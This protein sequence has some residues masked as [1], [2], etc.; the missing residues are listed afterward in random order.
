MGELELLLRI[1][2]TIRAVY[3]VDEDVGLHAHW[4]QQ[5]RHLRSAY[6]A[7]LHTE[8]DAALTSQF[9][10][11]VHAFTPSDLRALLPVVAAENHVFICA[12]WDCRSRSKAGK[13]LGLADPRHRTLDGTHAYVRAAQALWPGRVTYLL[14]NVAVEPYQGIAAQAS[15]AYVRAAFGTPLVLDAVQ[16]G[17]PMRRKRAYWTNAFVNSDFHDWLGRQA[18]PYYPLSAYLHQGSSPRM[19]NERDVRRHPNINRL[20]QPLLLGPTIV[21][22]PSAWASPE[23]PPPVVRPDGALSFLTAAE[24]E[25]ALGYRPGST[26]AGDELQRR[27]WLGQSFDLR[28]LNAILGYGHSGISYVLERPGRPP[29]LPPV[30]K[31]TP[32]PLGGE[33][34]AGQRTKAK[35]RIHNIQR[36]PEQP[37]VEAAEPPPGMI[38]LNL[39][40]VVGTHKPDCEGIRLCTLRADIPVVK[41][42][43]KNVFGSPIYYLVLP[44]GQVVGGEINEGDHPIIT[45]L[46]RAVE[47]AIERPPVNEPEGPVKLNINPE[48][49]PENRAKLEAFL[50]KWEAK[51]I[52]A[53][54]LETMG[55][56][57]G[58][59][60]RL[61]LNTNDTRRAYQRR[62][63]LPPEQADALMQEVQLFEAAGLLE[64]SISPVAA[65]PLVVRKKD[66]TW[67]VVIDYRPL[68]TILE[69]DRYAL[70]NIPEL[71][72]HFTAHLKANVFCTMD[73]YKGF[74]QLPLHEDDRYLTAFHS[75]YGGLK[76]W[77][78]M[79]M[80][81]SVGPPAFQRRVEW[82]IAGLNQ[83]RIFVDD[84][85]TGTRIPDLDFDVFPAPLDEHGYPT[86]PIRLVAKGKWDID[87]HLADMNEVFERFVRDGWTI[88]W[89]KCFWGY[90]VVS[91]LGHYMSSYGI[92]PMADKVKAINQLPQPG[93]MGTLKSF[94]GMAGYY[95]QR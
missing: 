20:N 68:N 37:K 31:V 93:N 45:E 48:L 35:P 32:S 94:L 71:F 91:Q 62:R 19:A 70:P 11:N 83:V 42:K 43:C 46:T 44:N 63:P 13:G 79:P 49:D 30:G 26:S 66:G 81:I 50:R 52:G 90:F 47:E 92:E 51:G 14:E 22:S 41:K 9:S 65:N 7:Q 6:P 1:G 73:L 24:R 29:S 3:A 23:E 4:A 80:G 64:D 95:E 60:L 18:L 89:E 12:G 84:V 36:Q 38:R 39:D 27:R 25:L 56:Y 16:V 72:A 85:T 53:R 88:K 17:S 76:Q 86:G 21:S 8:A 74:H 54:S 28:A 2:H 55:R 87:P 77:K 75:G 82:S 78:V 15:E 57:T 69:S 34:V 40:A 59:P 33:R 5:W 10:P 61:Q 67:R 58:P